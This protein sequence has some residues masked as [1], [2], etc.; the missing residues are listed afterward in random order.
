[1]AGAEIASPDGGAVV[2][3]GNAACLDGP[4][5]LIGLR[6]KVVAN[7]ALV[8]ARVVPAFVVAAIQAVELA[9]EALFGGHDAVRGAV[10]HFGRSAPRPF[11]RPDDISLAAGHVAVVIVGALIAPRRH[12]EGGRGDIAPVLVLLAL[13]KPGAAGVVA[14]AK[15][16]SCIAGGLATRRAIVDGNQHPSDR[17]FAVV[18]GRAVGM[19]GW[20]AKIRQA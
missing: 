10:G 1:M 5:V 7:D 15:E 16:P 17:I 6:R 13:I 20:Q 9:G 14:A 2:G 12:A 3:V 4:S 11:S 19:N 18:I 8:P